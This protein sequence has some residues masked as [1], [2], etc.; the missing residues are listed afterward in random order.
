[1]VLVT[2]TFYMGVP[3]SHVNPYRRIPET[4]SKKRAVTQGISRKLFPDF[5]Q[6]EILGH[7]AGDDS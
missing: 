1:M 3:E 5:F 2:N 6:I 4:I 7:E